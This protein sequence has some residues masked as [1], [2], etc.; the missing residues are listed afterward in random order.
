MST[1]LTQQLAGYG[2][3]LRAEVDALTRETITPILR[4]FF[5]R[6]R[7]GWGRR[8]I[9]LLRS[10][11]SFPAVGSS[12][13]LRLLLPHNWKRW[14]SSCPSTRADPE[15][16]RSGGVLSVMPMVRRCREGPGGWVQLGGGAQW[17][18]SSCIQVPACSV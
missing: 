18:R 13:M 2:D 17:G 16:R 12:T 10:V 6:S 8:S 11:S 15:L 7:N 5:W 4:R 3:I 1:G 9:R 14:T